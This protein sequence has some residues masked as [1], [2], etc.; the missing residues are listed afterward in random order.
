MFAQEL[1]FNK[2]K[3][4]WTG[5]K[6]IALLA[7][8]PFHDVENGDGNTSPFL[9]FIKPQGFTMIYTHGPRSAGEHSALK[10]FALSYLAGQ[11]NPEVLFA[12]ERLKCTAIAYFFGLDELRK[13]MCSSVI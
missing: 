7:R 8:M 12:A 11:C 10:L 9:T 2:G 1:L 5:K 4:P 13:V 6:K 3:W